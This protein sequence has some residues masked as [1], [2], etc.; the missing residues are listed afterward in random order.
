MMNFK[1]LQMGVLLSVLTATAQDKPV[2][3]LVF[4]SGAIFDSVYAGIKREL[5]SDYEIKTFR[6]DGTI[7]ADALA[8]QMVSS[9]PKAILA[10]DNAALDVVKSFQ[11]K[12]GMKEIPVFAGAMLQ[13]E[14]EVKAKG[15]ENACGVQFE[16]PAFTQFSNL[17]QVST[18]KFLKVGVI[19]RRDFQAMINLSKEQLKKDNIELKDY[20]IDCD[21]KVLDEKNTS[22]G[23]KETWKM[24]DAESDMAV[25][26]LAD[27]GLL[28]ARSMGEFWLDKVAKSKKPVVAPLEMFV[29]GQKPFGEMAL[30]SLS[31][32][33]VELGSQM[34]GLV[35]GVLED[36]ESVQDKGFEPLVSV[37]KYLNQKKADKIDW[38]LNSE[39]MNQIDKLY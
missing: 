10:L 1:Y 31:P 17:K 12:S 15:I 34:A 4:P 6:N 35:Q 19:Y 30:L 13:V 25:W 2:L 24:L 27:N 21:G 14:Q 18:S 22:K 9:N 28:T 37:K 33:F 16:V 38:K 3:D 11:A 32:D 5:A 8:A 26:V 29:N 20:C 23:L 39:M 7:G 36:G